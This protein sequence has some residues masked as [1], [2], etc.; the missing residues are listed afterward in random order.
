MWYNFVQKNFG[1]MKKAILVGEWRLLL[2]LW[3]KWRRI[4]TTRKTKRMMLDTANELREEKRWDR[5]M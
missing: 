4:V 1:L 5:Y 2:R 3:K